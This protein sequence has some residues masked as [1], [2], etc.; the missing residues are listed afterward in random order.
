MPSMGSFPWIS[1]Q[2]ARMYHV[3]F[4][5][6]IGHERLTKQFLHERKENQFRISIISTLQKSVGGQIS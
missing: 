2:Y 6:P 5:R 1:L 4:V 3:W